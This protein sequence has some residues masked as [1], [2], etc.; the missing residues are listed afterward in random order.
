[1]AEG[2]LAPLGQKTWFILLHGE[3]KKQE[4]PKTTKKSNANVDEISQG[5]SMWH[6]A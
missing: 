6:T 3:E 1:M 4:N 5:K 2:Q